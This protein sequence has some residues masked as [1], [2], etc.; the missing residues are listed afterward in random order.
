MHASVLLKEIMG[1]IFVFL[2]DKMQEDLFLITLYLY[3]EI[4]CMWNFLLPSIYKLVYFF[5]S[6]HLSIFEIPLARGGGSKAMC[7]A[8]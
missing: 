7:M 4:L 8:L 6:G 2:W 1:L 3:R 5:L